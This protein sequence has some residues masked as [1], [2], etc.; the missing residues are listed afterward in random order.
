M[1]SESLWQAVSQSG[2]RQP[3]AQLDGAVVQ[4]A[5]AR[6]DTQPIL[7]Q[8]FDQDILGDLGNVFSTFIESGQIWALLV[9]FV[10]GYMLRSVTTYK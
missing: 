2:W 9:G 4:S 6:Q 3:E 10:L 7:A 5:I 1:H 8:Q